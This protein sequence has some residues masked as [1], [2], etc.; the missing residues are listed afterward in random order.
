[1]RKL[2][3]G[4]LL[5]GLLAVGLGAGL[6]AV[7]PPPEQSSK[8]A[9]GAVHS[10]S[11]PE[12]KTIRIG[13]PAKHS[14]VPSAFQQGAFLHPQSISVLDVTDDGLIGVATMAFRHDQ[15]F[16]LLSP[17]GKVLWGRYVEPWAPFQV[18]VLP[19]GKRIGIGLAYSR[20]TDPSPTVAIFDGERGAETAQVDSFWDMGWLRYGE[21][22]WRSGW[23]VCMIGDLLVRRRTSLVTVASHDGAW[24]VSGLD[25]P[26]DG[27]SGGERRPYP[28]Q[29]QRPFRMAASGE[30]QVLAF[31][32]LAPRASE[33]ADKTKRRLRLPPALARV[34]NASTS[35]TLWTTG[36]LADAGAIPK[37]PEPALEF[38]E[39]AEDFNMKPQALAP[40]RAALALALNNDGSRLALA[41]YGGWLRIKR[42]RAIGQ[43]NPDHSIPFCPRQKGWLRVFKSDGLE[44]PSY[45]EQVKVML[46]REGLFD[47]HW[48]PR[49]DTVWC[50]PMSWFARGMAG[51]PWLPADPHANQLYLFDTRRNAWTASWSFPDAVSDFVLH[52]KGAL[53]S[54]WDGKTYLIGEDGALLTT[55]E[56]GAPARLSWN[57]AG[58]FAVIGSQNGEVWSVDV[59]GKL[60]WKTR[61]PVKDVPAAKK[62]LAPVFEEVPIYSVGRV[63]KEHAYVGDI[64]LIKT[65]EGS[66]LVDC[67]GVSGIPF[68]WQRMRAAGVDPK[69]VRYALLTHSHGDHAGTAHLWRAQ[70]AKIVAPATAAFTVT[71]AMPTWSDYSVWPPCPIDMPLP[72][73][74]PG[75]EAEITL[76][77]LRIKAIFV[78]GHSVDSVLYVV[79][80]PG[81]R[82]LFTGD[83]GFEGVSNIL[84]RSWGDR[85]KAL[86]V[87]RVVRRQVLPLAPD[88]VFTGHGPRR[89]GT[90]FL[91]DLLMRSE[92]A[93]Q[94]QGP[95]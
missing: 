65:P 1:M 83:I 50:V 31:G 17:E 34:D 73:K 9:A 3:S 2:A 19:G 59:E 92:E 74:R 81:K 91:R 87:I 70:G 24:Q 6:A 27:K 57:A 89:D 45:V 61:L 94:G 21:G 71:W 38:G 35:T 90:G 66:I 12:L 93:V 86:P 11:E 37:P 13:Q 43:W 8:A 5:I 44:K 39:F 36:P 16:W 22:D 88:F 55:L 4:T 28:L 56:V 63:G 95:K 30:G 33:L 67:G 46:P 79:D 20:V 85:D 76:C 62:P 84:H 52:P 32:Y 72:L 15:N 75:D 23:P 7:E 69:D 42:E 25:R 49:E 14:N 18:A 68:T 58:R 29:Y 10:S 77:G 60:R 82:V 51:R 26:S 48:G 78:P 80:F 53:V 64:W 41:E 40:F 54:C 47:I